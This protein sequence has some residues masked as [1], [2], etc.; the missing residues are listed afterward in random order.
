MHVMLLDD[1]R[2]AAARIRDLLLREDLITALEVPDKPENI[3]REYADKP[4]HLVFIRLGNTSFNGLKLAKELN[5]INPRIKVVFISQSRDYARYAFEAGAADYLLEPI[6]AT[7]LRLTL[8]QY[9]T[10][11]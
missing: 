3:L 11:S 2:K 1:D 4:V 10:G 9:G 6:D 5:K 8:A 7:R